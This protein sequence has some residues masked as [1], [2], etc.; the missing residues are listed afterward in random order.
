VIRTEC[1]FHIIGPAPGKP[2]MTRRDKWAK[3]PCVMAYWSWADQAR[4]TAGK[5]FAPQAAGDVRL[6]RITA[7][8]RPPES[9]SYTRR[10]AA[11]GTMKRTRPD[12]DNI[13][14]AV[15]DALWPDNDAAVGDVEV[16]RRYGTEDMT[17][18]AI[19]RSD[20]EP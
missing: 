11:I 13:A 20:N 6:I 12:P 9:W 1:V 16:R 10:T 19:T 18:V 4:A 5:V 3:R 17:E 14:K 2:R 7:F 8:Y 15:L